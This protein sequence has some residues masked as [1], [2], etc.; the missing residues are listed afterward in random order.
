MNQLTKQQAEQT[1]AKYGS[2]SKAV[3]AL[4]VTRWAFRV[5]LGKEGPSA[6][7]PQKP[8]GGMESLRELFGKDVI[9]KRKMQKR[10]DAVAEFITTTL[11]ERQWMRDADVREELGLAAVDFAM[12]RQEHTHL[13]LQAT[14]EDGQR[15]LIWCHPDYLDEARDTINGHRKTGCKR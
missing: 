9:A 4:G 1:V 2:E 12:V 3:K 7:I 8:A 10:H 6:A 14:A 13:T 15:V 11:K 5:A